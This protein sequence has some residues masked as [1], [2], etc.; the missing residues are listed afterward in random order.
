MLPPASHLILHPINFFSAYIQAF[1][2]DT[3]RT[4]AITAERRQKKV[5]DVVKRNEYRKA[6]GL[7][8][9][10]GFGGWSTLGDSSPT[11]TTT[12]TINTSYVDNDCG[13]GNGNGGGDDDD[14]DE[15]IVDGR[16][17]PVDPPA[18]TTVTDGSTDGST[19]GTKYTR[20]RV[21]TDSEGNKRPLK[22]WFGIW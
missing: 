10:S 2:L 17:T 1:K 16:L 12:T 7:D 11:T 20:R 19:N 15:A 8:T 21:F 4:S 14:D 5:D 22:M 6:H 3:D 13:D 9:R 18:S